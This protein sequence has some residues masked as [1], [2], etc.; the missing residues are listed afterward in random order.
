MPMPHWERCRICSSKPADFQVQLANDG[1]LST[2]E[3]AAI[4]GQID[5]VVTSVDAIGGYTSYN[6]SNLFDGSV[7]LWAAG[8]TLDLPEISSTVQGLTSIDGE[9]YTLADIS[10][11]GDLVGDHENAQLVL[12][13]AISEVSTARGRIGTFQNGIRSRLDSIGTALELTTQAESLI[14]DTDYAFE[15]ANFARLRTLGSASIKTISIINDN[16][17]TLLDLFK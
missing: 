13:A 7:S 6:G 10:S 9:D 3:K 5:S 15:V 8:D 11:D 1:A 14:R 16:N 12:D 4:Q 2:E 17:R